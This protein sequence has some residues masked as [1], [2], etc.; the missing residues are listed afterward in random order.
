[1]RWDFA[2]AALLSALLSVPVSL[3]LL[4]MP[5]ST[6]ADASAV[7]MLLLT[8]QF[9]NAIGSPTVPSDPRLVQAAQNY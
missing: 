3:V 6:T 4:A 7:D 8:N 5:L 2:R 1:M 9:R